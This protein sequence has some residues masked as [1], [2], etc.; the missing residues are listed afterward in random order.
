MIQKNP[1]TH[2]WQTRPGLSWVYRLIGISWVY[3]FIT[4]LLTIGSEHL[5][6]G[7]RLKLFEKTHGFVLDVGCGPRMRTPVPRGVV[8]GV[9]VNPSYLQAYTGG[10]VDK[11]PEEPFRQPPPSRRYGY[12][13]DAQSLPFRD[14][15]FDEIRATAFFHHLDEA[16]VRNSLIEMRRCLRPGGRFVFFDAVWPKRGWIRPLAWLT[17]RFDRGRHMRTEEQLC[18][19]LTDTLQEKWCFRRMTYSYTGLECIWAVFPR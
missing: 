14:H 7:I 9:D 4:M 19:L 10:F 17:L 16:A 8:V 3:K 12:L 18:F 5:L 15:C 2:G 13:A 1:P 11:D 6:Y